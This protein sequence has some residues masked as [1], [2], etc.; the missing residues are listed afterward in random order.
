MVSG[1]TV[2][3]LGTAQ[4]SPELLLKPEESGKVERETFIMQLRTLQANGETQLNFASTDQK[5]IEEKNYPEVD[6]PRQ[7]YYMMSRDTFSGSP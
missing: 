5:W 1:A 2:P 6:Q 3:H 7:E 4:N